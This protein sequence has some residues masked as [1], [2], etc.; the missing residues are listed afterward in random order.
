MM[1]DC[2]GVIEYVNP[3]FEA[4]TGYTRDEACGRSPRILRSGEQGRRFTRRL[5]KTILAGESNVFRRNSGQ[6]Q[7]ERRTVLRRREHLLRAATAR[8][9]SRISF[10]MVGTLPSA[11][12]S[13]PQHCCVAQK[14]DAIGR[15]AGGVT[16]DFNNLLTIITSYSELA[17]DEVLGNPSLSAKVRRF[18]RRPGAPPRADAPVAGLQ[19]E[20]R[21]RALRVADLNEVISDIAKTLPR[22]I[23]EDIE[24]SFVPGSG[25]G[26]V[27]LDPLQIE[28]VLMNL[29]SNA[30]DAMPQG[31]HLRIETS[32]VI[33]DAL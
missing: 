8:A 21:P 13:K 7:K 22:L 27:R 20:E 24:F 32:N 2:H 10:P 5:W 16:H 18:S 26:G 19:P 3:A 14:M 31:G 6:S 25:L 1:T 4:L 28:Q 23:G 15:L 9:R 12:A 33:L 30:R 17:L 11:C 29:S